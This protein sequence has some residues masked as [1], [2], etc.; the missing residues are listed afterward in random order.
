[1]STAN[2]LAVSIPHR[3]G[4]NRRVN[5]D[6]AELTAWVERT[7]GTDGIELSRLPAE[8]ST[9]QFF[10]VST[11]VSTFVAMLSPPDTEDNPRFVR[12]ADLF[13]SHGL[14]TPR[15]HAADLD[16]G[17]LLLEDLGERDFAA[18]YA[19]GEIDAPLDAAV[20]EL[21]RLQSVVSDDIP[22]YTTAR[23]RDELAIFTD[24]LLG[25]LVGVDV[26]Q[27]YAGVADAL[28]EATQGVPQRTVHRDYH[29]RN[30]IWRN[31]SCVGIVDFQ[32]A[33]V[34]PCC[35]DIASLLRDCYV[36]FDEARV[37]AW[38]HRFFELA[39][40]DCEESAFQRAFDLTAIQRQL[41]AVG[42]FARLYLNRGRASH[43]GDIA[44]VLGRIS[45]LG[46]DY[47]ETAEFAAWIDIELVPRVVHRLEGLPCVP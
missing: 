47:P 30:L 45:R 33:L 17:M 29:C 34:G 18:A 22:P 1:M 27:A 43:L 32:D 13:R 28:V 44:P 25:R 14:R 35:Y 6:V 9:R 46:R 21:V 15:V 11:G 5:Q 37:A 39:E 41:K 31:D 26:P 36:E 12:L 23:F 20:H 10:R 2:T 8:A 16:R 4:D 42:I 7:L 38:R 3:L 24:W 19:S 40:L